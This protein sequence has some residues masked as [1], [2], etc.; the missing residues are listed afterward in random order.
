MQIYQFV[1]KFKNEESFHSECQVKSLFEGKRKIL[2]IKY[3][4]IFEKN[5]FKG[6][7]LSIDDITE[8]VSAQKKGSLVK[9]CKIHCS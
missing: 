7:I 1:K 6:L 4:K 3:S 5:Q 8:L 2:N 9:C